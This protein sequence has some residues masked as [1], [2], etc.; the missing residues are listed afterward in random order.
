MS[1]NGI[2]PTI[3]LEIGYT[4]TYDEYLADADFLLEGS[5]GMICVVVMVK[6]KPVSPEDIQCRS[7]FVKVHE[8]NLVSGAAKKKDT[9]RH[10]VI[11]MHNRRF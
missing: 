2:W 8:Y 5:E 6:V 9:K 4:E 1:D 7:G 3:A 11:I 10:G